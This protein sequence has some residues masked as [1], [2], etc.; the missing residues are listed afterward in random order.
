MYN[1]KAFTYM[2]RKI[3]VLRNIVSEELSGGMALYVMCCTIK[4]FNSLN[5]QQQVLTRNKG[6]PLKYKAGDDTFM[7]ER[8]PTIIRTTCILYF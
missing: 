6:F 8:D 2:L 1:I 7:F 3:V 5:M 4:F